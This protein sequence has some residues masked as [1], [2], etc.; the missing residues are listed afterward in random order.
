MPL[1]LNREIQKMFMHRWIVKFVLK[2]LGCRAITNFCLL[3]QGCFRVTGG[4][5]ALSETIVQIKIT[6]REF[7]PGPP[8]GTSDTP[9]RYFPPVRNHRPDLTG[10]FSS[11]RPHILASW[12]VSRSLL[13]N[14]AIGE[15]VGACWHVCQLIRGKANPGYRCERWMVSTGPSP[16]RG[17]GESHVKKL[18]DIGP[19]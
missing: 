11:C 10:T 18:C 1:H 13:R 3:W 16:D 9:R 19:A 5:N 14:N 7:G 17:Q 15:L 4:L 12:V 2:N 8:H 6:G